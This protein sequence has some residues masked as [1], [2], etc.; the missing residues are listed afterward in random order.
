MKSVKISACAAA[1]LFAATAA[2]PAGPMPVARSDIVAP[3]TSDQAV[4]VHYRYYHHR[5]YG[6]RRHWVPRHYAWYGH[7]RHW[8]RGHYAWY[9]HHRYWGPRRYA[10]YGPYRYW[11]PRHYVW[12]R[13]RTHWLPGHY[14]WYRH[15][16]H[17][18]PGHYAYGYR[19]RYAYYGAPNP[20]GA[21]A[22]TA[23]GLAGVGVN[24]AVGTA[25]VLG[26]GW[27]NFWGGYC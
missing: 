1:V 2:A 24:T 13:P 4:Q 6:W 23:V 9:G 14:A 16:R 21:A 20:V 7:H 17:W 11:G 27:C 5:H 25:R 12:Y 19:G 3:S 8:V 18:V 26:H 10:W 15:H 22:G